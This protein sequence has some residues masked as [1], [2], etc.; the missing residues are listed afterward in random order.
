MPI[1]LD[2][3]CGAGGASKG[4]Y[5]AGFNIIIGVDTQYFFRY[6]YKLVQRDVLDYLLKEDLS[7]FDLIHASPPCQAYTWCSA[8]HRNRGI[9]YPKLI[10]ELRE[11]LRDKKKD[12]KFEYVIENT[13]GSNLYNPVFLEGYMF[14]LPLK[15]RRLF[16]CSF[17]VNQPK[18]INS[19]SNK[20]FVTLAGNGGEAISYKL[21]D[22]KLATD[23]WWMN[24]KQ[25]VQAIP[26]KYTEYIG[27]EFLKQ[28]G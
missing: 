12:N 24:R 6:P 10:P 19:P 16:E 4:Y 22:Y 26:P 14:G 11:I 2:C 28:R 8:R 3:F 15:R 20:V 7:K 21:D 5:D 23:I 18:V 25:I 13:L 17:R 1:L 9:I 27:K